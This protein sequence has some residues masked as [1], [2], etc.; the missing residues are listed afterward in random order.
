MGW[1]FLEQ[2]GLSS[3]TSR[4]QRTKR[5]P[6]R[7]Q[8]ELLEDR[9][10][11]T[12]LVSVVGNPNPLTDAA[13][14]GTF[15]LRVLFDGSMSTAPA[16]T[17]IIAFPTANENPGASLVLTGGSFTTTN[18]TNDTYLANYAATDQNVNILNIDVNVSGA[19]NQ[20]DQTVN[21]QTAFN[22]FSIDTLSPV[23][24]SVQ[25]NKPVILATD[26]NPPG[27]FII[28]ITYKEPMDTSSIP[29]I[30]F[31]KT[32]TPTI[33][34]TQTSGSWNPAGT[35]YTANY[36]PISGSNNV[37]PAISIIVSGA[38]KAGNITQLPFT[39]PN[40]FSIDTR[41]NPNGVFPNGSTTRLVGDF[42]GDT[43]SDVA[44]YYPSTGQWFVALSTG[45]SFLA[46]KVWSTFGTPTGYTRQLV[47]D[48]NNDGK[49]DIANFYN[50]RQY[51]RIWVSMSDGGKF[52]TTLWADYGATITAS[53][54]KFMLVGDF[55]GDS[56]DD[57]AAFL[58]RTGVARWYVSASNGS[59]KFN[60]TL[61]A[62]L[63]NLTTTGWTNAVV[64]DFNNDDKD[65]IGNFYNPSSSYARWLVSTSSGTNFS[66]T[67]WASLN[68]RT[69]WGIQRAG[70]FNADGRIDLASFNNTTGDWWV[71]LSTGSAF[72]TT[73]WLDLLPAT[74][75]QTVGDFNKD[76]KADVG[77][78]SLQSNQI[79][80]G[81]STGSNFAF[82]IWGAPPFNTGLVS[83][84]VGDFNGDGRADLGHFFTVSGGMQWWV[85]LATASNNFNTTK[86]R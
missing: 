58:N 42:N 48:F 66:T 78:V 45:S 17:P 24:Q 44:A 41:P 37:V 25:V 12:A 16:N 81:Q 54:W 5:R 6:D 61:W 57:I 84:L 69:G 22:V 76:G 73:M 62:N 75:F 47:G 50:V 15:T 35:V 46:P 79:A 63:G 85:S 77:I 2:F 3:Y 40:A 4:R 27:T 39:Q 7:L 31:S 26:T 74:Y 60:T 21:A 23:V 13:V 53:G 30:A 64:G 28:T 29:T 18:V 52:N 20:A 10:T 32:V 83:E 11:P 14:P 1:S 51:A 80:V 38:R 56:S 43:L 19:R 86:W 49:D 36:T 9:T 68:P 72:T 33:P 82:S 65:D 8:V 55:N 67:L 71:S 70:D 34:A 59:T